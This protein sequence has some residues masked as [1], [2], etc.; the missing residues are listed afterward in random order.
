MS[1]DLGPFVLVLLQL[2]RD[3]GKLLFSVFQALQKR[4][5]LLAHLLVLV[6]ELV[7]LSF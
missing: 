5:V 1:P 2:A 4:I 3:F 7:N 6:Q